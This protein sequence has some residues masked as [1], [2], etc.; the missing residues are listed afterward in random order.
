LF[1]CFTQAAEHRVL[2]VSGLHNNKAKVSLLQELAVPRGIAIEQK[3]ENSFGDI[4]SAVAVF[5]EYDLVILDAASANESRKTYE[6]YRDA[7]TGIRTRVLPI[8]WLDEQV[9]RRGIEQQQARLLH[10]YYGNGGQKNFSRML[11]YLKFN[12]LTNTGKAIA[13]PIIYPA[14][15]IY[16]PDYDGLVFST[17]DDYF[18]FRKLD[19]P[20]QP[21]VAILMN[22]A[23]IESAQT[24][25]I[26]ATI[27]GLEA[28]NMLALPF[29]FQLSPRA[30]DYTFLLQRDGKTIVDLIIN[31]RTIHWA[32]QRKAEFEKL[33][34]PVLQ[35]LTYFEG[36]QADWEQSAQGI[37]AGMT[38]FALVL[39]ETAGVIDPLIV[40]ATNQKTGSAEII[41]Y[42]LDHLVNKAGNLVALRHKPNSEKKLTVMVWGDRDVGASFLNVAD[43]LR[44]ISG[45]LN[46]GGYTVGAVDANYFTARVDR[47]LSPFYRDYEL[48]ALIKDDLAELM[49]VDD[50]LR[51][52]NSLPESVTG[53]INQYWGK[54][55]DNFMV[56]LRDGKAQ[57]VL[58][59][60]RNGN[61]LIMRQPP[62]ADDKDEDKRIYHKGTVPMNHFYLAAYYYTRKFWHSDAIIHLGTHGSQEYLAGKERGLSRYDEGNL[63]VWDTPVIYPF[64]VD[65][66]GE[67]MQT[68]RRGSATVVSHMTPPFAAAGLQGDVADLHEL[69]HQYKTLDQGGVKKKTGEQIVDKCLE[70]HICNDLGWQQTQI[71]ADFGGFLN[72]LHGYMEE[73]AVQ[74]QPLGLHSFGELPEQQLVISTLVQMMDKDFVQQAAVFEEQYYRQNDQHDHRHDK[75]A[76][77]EHNDI[78]QHSA[79]ENPEALPGFKTVRDFVVVERAVDKRMNADFRQQ[80]TLAR[81]RYQNLSGI[82]E[83]ESLTDALA[84]RY[85]PVK[86]GGDPVR[87][88][89]SLPT[90]FNLYGF[91][92]ARLPTPAAWQQGRE[93][94]GQ[95]IADYY[96]KHGRYPDKLAFSLWSIEAMRHYGVLESQA[97]YAMG[98]RPVWSDDGRMTGTEIIPAA[99]LKRP[100]IDVVLSATG[101]YRDAF[102]NVMQQLAKA[103]QQ[104][105]EL[106]EANN[107]LW[108]NSQRIKTDLIKAGIDPQEA[109]YLSTVRIFSSAS[110]QYGSGVDDAVFASDSWETDAKIADNYLGKMG[111]FFGADDNRWGEKID[112]LDLYGKQ[113]SGTDVA[114][115][116]RSSNLYGMLSSDDPFEYFGALSLAVRNLDGQSPEMVIGN[117]RDA[118]NPRLETAAAFLAKELRTRMLHKRWIQEMQKEGYSGAVAMSS[119]VDNFWGWQVVDPNVVRADQWQAFYEVYIEDKLELNL[120]EWFEQVNPKSQANMIVR[121]LEAVRKEYWQAD[122]AVQQRLIERY[123]ELVNRYD[124]LV[125]NEKLR[126]FIHQQSAG[127]GFELKLPA[128]ADNGGQLQ[129]SVQGQQ[130]EKVEEQASSEWRWDFKLLGALAIALL[131]IAAGGWRQ[132]RRRLECCQ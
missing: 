67:A 41:S 96:R 1:S 113:L 80:I 111:Y 10:A 63:A 55:E 3:P 47:I 88:P 30:S 19:K 32:N 12:V 31:F 78:H 84:G 95:L 72:A 42:Q 101:L 109:L 37:S 73:L 87:N 16:H 4:P 34:V 82:R 123:V 130:L 54:A 110:G 74:N 29:Y 26:D 117:L 61:M 51:W 13:A 100:R 103:I 5:N 35:A 120:D 45:H 36:D 46:A 81:E 93:L 128:P 2:F 83:L 94:V 64:I 15:G 97:L 65:D 99:E 58:P 116:A 9:F 28:K 48:D 24:A 20:D 39:P 114:L 92:P 22:R 69:M 119:N 89:E 105:A 104:V 118:D 79:G 56:V 7:L 44:S 126:E 127:F 107:S 77:S 59:R 17:L 131:L 75:P 53:P 132:Y 108:D 102:P 121:M 90:G 57:F 70:I 40:A 115:F 122:A 98:V 106:K 21:V 124:L 6:K 38:A 76:H 23:Q 68:K 43:S 52:F 125:N 11:D 8:Q 50:Y 112:G 49:P 91:D 86:T 27:A 60:I 66:V 14:S 129:Q 85:I 33:G 71:D 25:L 62:R 18:Q